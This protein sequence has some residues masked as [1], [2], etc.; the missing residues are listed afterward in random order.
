MAWHAFQ[1]YDIEQGKLNLYP[2]YAF[3]NLPSEEVHGILIKLYTKKFI[4]ETTCIK[5]IKNCEHFKAS[6][7]QFILH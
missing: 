6:F 5:V 4:D 1:K 2:K 7:D 3:Y